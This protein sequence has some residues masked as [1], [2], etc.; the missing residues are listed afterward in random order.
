MEEESTPFDVF[1]VVL[2]RMTWIE[3][4]LGGIRR[5]DHRL[6]IDGLAVFD[7]RRLF[8]G[9]TPREACAIRHQLFS[10]F[11]LRQSPEPIPF[12]RD[13]S[14]SL[15]GLCTTIRCTSL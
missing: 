9:R 14:V 1:L 3:D 13:F 8:H 11:T 2:A 10:Y 6:G 7:E 5:L 12:A 4:E 15:C